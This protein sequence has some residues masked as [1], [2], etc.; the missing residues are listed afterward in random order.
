MLRL[1]CTSGQKGSHHNQS[2]GRTAWAAT[3]YLVQG[4]GASLR[5]ESLDRSM[6]QKVILRDKFDLVDM[7]RKLLS[8]L[9]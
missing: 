1:F 9:D 6:A 3:L 8:S 4:V 5:D 2:H 7:R